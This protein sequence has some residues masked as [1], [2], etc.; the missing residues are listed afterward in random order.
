MPEISVEQITS[1]LSIG[2]IVLFAWTIVVVLY[3]ALRGFF[4]GWRYGT[5]HLVMTLIFILAAVFTLR[6][7]LDFAAAFDLSSYGLP[8]INLVVNEVNISVSWTT[9][10]ETLENLLSSALMAM[11][12]ALA[13]AEILEVVTPFAFSLIAL[14]LLFLESILLVTVWA[15]LSWILWHLIFKRFI[16]KKKHLTA[17]QFEKKSSYYRKRKF[18]RKQE[19]GSYIVLHRKTTYRKGRLL[20]SFEGLVTG[21]LAL[22]LFLF[23][24]TSIVNSVSSGWNDLTKEEETNLNLAND[25]TYQTINTFLEAYDN[26]LFAQVFFSWSKD[27]NGI[28]AD[29]KLMDY[30]TSLGSK[31]GETSFLKELP[32]LV[33]IGSYLIE[34]GLLSGE[35]GALNYV[36][37]FTSSL[38][39]NILRALGDSGLVTGLM[40]V[41]LNLA[42]NIETVATYLKTD[43]NI[44]F[45]TFDYEVTLDTAADIY[46]SLL[47]SGVLDDVNFND[48]KGTSVIVDRLLEGQGDESFNLLFSS[49]S[50]D[51]LALVNDLIATVCYVQAVKEYEERQ[52]FDDISTIGVMDFMPEFSDPD[53]NGNGIPD[54]VPESFFAIDWGHE[55]SLVYTNLIKVSALEPGLIVDLLFPN[56]NEEPENEGNSSLHDSSENSFANSKDM[57]DTILSLVADHTEEIQEIVAGK[58]EESAKSSLLGSELL[59]RGMPRILQIMEATLESSETPV[60]V[61]LSPVIDYLKPQEGETSLT[62]SMIRTQDEFRSILGVLMEFTSTEEGKMFLKNSKDMPGIYLDPEGMLLGIE[63]GLLS[64]FKKALISMDTSFTVREVL[65]NV[66]ESFLE[67][68]DSPLESLGFTAGFDFQVENLGAEL[69]HILDSYASSQS[70]ITLILS[71]SNINLSHQSELDRVF[72]QLALHSDELVS[73]LTTIATSPIFNPVVVGENGESIYNANIAGLLEIV[74][75]P[76]FGEEVTKDALDIVKQEHFDLENEFSAIGDVLTELASQHIFLILNSDVDISN[77]AAISFEN[78]FGAIGESQIMRE[79]LPEFLDENILR[80]NFLSES[81]SFKN[82]KDWASEGKALDIVIDSISIVGTNITSLDYF[83]SDAYAIT[84]LIYGLSQT[85]L[86]DDAEGNYGFSSFIADE[87]IESVIGQNDEGL[88][89]SLFADPTVDENGNMTFERLRAAVSSITKEGWVKECNVLERL[90]YNMQRASEMTFF[91]QGVNLSEVDLRFVSNTI[92]DLLDSAVFGP[93]MIPNF[94]KQFVQAMVDGGF[95]EFANADITYLWET[96]LDGLKAEMNIL[97]NILYCVTDPVYGFLGEDG[98]LLNVLTSDYFQ[99]H[100]ELVPGIIRYNVNPLLTYMEG[101]NVLN[102]TR[103]GAIHPTPYESILIS[104]EEALRSMVPEVPTDPDLP[105]DPEDPEIGGILDELPPDVEDLLGDLFPDLFPKQA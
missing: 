97:I 24:L 15:F 75:S 32:N 88:F 67:G 11:D 49:L 100:P 85:S 45:H 19:D 62:P 92:D 86:F 28:T 38:A 56:A 99:E 63:D 29:A 25:E 73:L 16:R 98:T 87:F 84:Q 35:N 96:D 81:A 40:P 42:T 91:G 69:A 1:I 83:Q 57:T 30:I 50:K 7:L 37:A 14:I 27:E 17:E 65:P 6:P 77:F 53:I 23:P 90:I 94:Y 93:I 76:I 3:S 103:E 95:E 52:S 89:A 59:C 47:E 22:A 72:N 80:D 79:I 61:D 51:Q 46:S 74:L 12:V 58:N 21:V 101:S 41:A 2:L 54:A 10:L 55:L 26:S 18:V 66:I 44:D 82:I 102:S 13:P 104:L 78:I 39:P 8:A 34:G 5:Y 20:S 31:E 71:L 4:R 60:D 105:F 33:K 43:A 36:A 64:S 48:E 70:L 9:P 68:E